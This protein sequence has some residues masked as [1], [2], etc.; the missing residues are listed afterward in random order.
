[1]KKEQKIKDSLR[2]SILDGI[3]YSSMVGFGESF[4]SAFAVFLNAT[5]FQIGLIGSLPQM[6]GSLSQLYS[7]KLMERIKSRK[8][9]V[10]LGAVLQGIMYIPV[11]LT[12]FFGELRV[13]HLILFVS[14]Y[15]VFSAIVS[16]AWNS[17][18]GD[19]V[20][21]NERG[22]YFGRRNKL[23]GFAS[24]IGFVLGGFVLQRISH[25]NRDVFIGFIAIFS[26]ALVSRMVSVS[27]VL[28]KYEPRYSLHKKLQFSFLDFIK[29]AG[30]N[31]YGLFTIFLSLMNFATYIAAPYF[32]AYMLNDL[33]FDY[34]T[35]TV[36]S[37]MSLL[38]KY[39]SMPIWGKAS[40]RFGA[41]KVL[42]LTGF[43]VPTV[44]ILWIFSRNFWYLLAIQAW[45]GFI[46]AGFELS[47]FKFIY[48]TTTPEK[49]ATCV[50]YYNVMNG[51][52]MFLGALLGSFL[53]GFNT[54]FWSD[55]LF[56][57]M[58]S[59]FA[60]FIPA[61]LFIPKL[62]EVRKVEDVKYHELFFNVLT[63]M[64]TIGII[65]DLIPLPK[66]KKTKKLLKSG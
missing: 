63:T 60:R 30:Y 28:K 29:K 21:E 43:F 40:D 57:F 36:V 14:L 20:P 13:F 42:S 46:W 44:A 48:D 6:L 45:S 1:M 54:F 31:N 50:A 7:N 58:L 27:Y 55:Y 32:A 62:K 16:P 53:L 39:I 25:A 10:S 56:I 65:Y 61:I 59:T 17:W 26:I 34:L 38:V 3:F 19:L 51:T 52:G 23:A 33:R 49:R 47:S 5:S 4:F 9:L 35:F 41:I 15:W 8:R 12:Y 22:S 37:T 66:E 18:M 24:Y 64:P 2:Y 11:I